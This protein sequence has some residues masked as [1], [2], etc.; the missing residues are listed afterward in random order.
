MDKGYTFWGTCKGTT[1]AGKS[2]K[3]TVVYANG[4]CQAHGGDSTEF[5][6]ERF[7]KIKAKAIHRAERWRKRLAAAHPELAQFIRTRKERLKEQP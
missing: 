2:C 6:R 5:M 3:R 1:K 4:Y 7:A